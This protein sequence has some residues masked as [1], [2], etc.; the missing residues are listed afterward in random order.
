VV[1]VFDSNDCAVILGCKYLNLFTSLCN[2]SA[3]LL[4]AELTDGS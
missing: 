1:P 3:L 4:L 2:L